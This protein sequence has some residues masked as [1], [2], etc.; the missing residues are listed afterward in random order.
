MVATGHITPEPRRF[1]IWLPRPLWIIVV[2]VVL[3]VGVG[4][5][6]GIHSTG[7]PHLENA[8][9]LADVSGEID[10]G[11]PDPESERDRT[12]T[13]SKIGQVEIDGVNFPFGD[14][15]D[16]TGPCLTTDPF[17]LLYSY[18]DASI[19]GLRIN[20]RANQ[21]KFEFHLIGNE[22][23]R[24]LSLQAISTLKTGVY[25]R[26]RGRLMDAR[27]HGRKSCS[28]VVEQIQSIPDAPLT[29]IDFVDRTTVFEGTAEAGGKFRSATLIA[30]L[31]GLNEWPQS[32]LGK[33]VFAKGI[34][35]RGKA[36]WEI[37]RPAWS[38]I[39]LADQIGD[40][41]SLD[42]K[43]MSL[44]GCW[45]FDYREERLYVTTAAGPAMEFSSDEHGRRAQVSGKLVRQLRPALNQI[46]LKHDRDLVPCFV[47][48]GAKVEYPNDASTWSDRY[49]SLYSSSFS[50][51]DGVPEL[52][53]ENSYRRNLLGNETTARLYAERNCE[54]IRT[55][56]ATW[57]PATA[58][59]LATRMNDR[60]LPDP[61]RLL[62]ATLLARTN[63]ARGRLFLTKVVE[64]RSRESLADALFCLGI[65]P[66]I[67]SDKVQIETDVEW[68]GQLLIAVMTDRK[69]AGI[70]YRRSMSIRGSHPPISVADAAV[71]HSKIPTVLVKINTTAARKVLIDYVLA[72]SEFADSVVGTLCRSDVL[73]PIDDLL[74]LEG[75]TQDVNDRRDILLQL[76]RQKHPAAAERFLKDLEDS[77]V[78][79]D[80]R[81]HSSPE[82]LS[83]IRSHIK[84][85]RGESLNHAQMLLVLGEKD[86]IVAI[87]A[88]LDDPQWKDKSL[89]LF[90]LARLRDSRAIAPVA[91]ILRTA[92]PGYFNSKSELDA[93]AAVCQGLGAIAQTGSKESIPALI[94]LLRVDLARFGTSIDRAG[95]QRIVASHLI[96]LT[97]ESFGVDAKAWAK[98][99]Q[100]QPKD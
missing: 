54:V 70:A 38:L 1:S 66:S 49:R 42:G 47:I 32:V 16:V 2:V 75:V 51:R 3:L 18:G 29:F 68:A 67:A 56:L 65:F 80:F 86:P 74:K 82:A 24:K 93:C 39:D 28:L 7:G 4:L 84:Q 27:V 35:R 83:G 19:L 92:P 78:Y 95:F 8:D 69:P 12:G 88:M 58:D 85:L 96:E 64:T 41:V 55:M 57:T 89:A 10:H 94:D 48:R 37:E 98:W 46:S 63:D 97:G 6:I 11:G 17:K 15:L 25:Y 40:T 79:M 31:E 50:M 44:N 52:L 14:M 21:E 13:R 26:V 61:I 36:G 76:L 34:V 9:D 81:D 62:Y 71:I 77:F 90:E 22:K 91:R 43:L 99:R 60:I 53:A 72:K 23:D 33:K 59:V 30:Q 20:D 45:W 73:L 100:S 87:L 5:T